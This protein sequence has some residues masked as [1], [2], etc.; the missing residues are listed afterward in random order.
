MNGAI[1]TFTHPCPGFHG[2]V[3]SQVELTVYPLLHGISAYA[4]GRTHFREHCAIDYKLVLAQRAPMPAAWL[5]GSLAA[6]SADRNIK[7]LDVPDSMPL[8]TR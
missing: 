8:N 5:P 6:R 1:A 4:T 2:C 3:L 7:M